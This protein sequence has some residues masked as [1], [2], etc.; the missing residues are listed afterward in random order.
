[1]FKKIFRYIILTLV[2][3][4]GLFININ[5]DKQLETNAPSSKTV[6]LSLNETQQFSHGTNNYFLE[7]IENQ[8]E[9]LSTN[10]SSASLTSAKLSF[11]LSSSVEASA[12]NKNRDSV[13]NRAGHR[14]EIKL[15]NHVNRAIDELIDLT[16]PRSKAYRD[17]SMNQLFNSLPYGETKVL[18]T[19]AKASTL[20]N[21]VNKSRNAAIVANVYKIGRNGGRGPLCGFVIYKSANPEEDLYIED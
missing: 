16:D 15:K 14:A 4:A 19:G 8:Q 9:D 1:M 10:N 6:V 3:A 20:R 12:W 2:V 11:N 5:V 17:F 13:V 21:I 7:P 18:V